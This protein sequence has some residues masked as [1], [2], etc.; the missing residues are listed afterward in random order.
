MI[1]CYWGSTLQTEVET[2]LLPLCPADR[3]ALMVYLHFVRHAN[4]GHASAETTPTL[5]TVKHILTILIASIQV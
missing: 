4:C 5:W 1:L 2:L 3:R